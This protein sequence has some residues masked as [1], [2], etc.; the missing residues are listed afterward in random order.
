MTALLSHALIC[1]WIDDVKCNELMLVVLAL[2]NG[3]LWSKNTQPK[4]YKIS[5]E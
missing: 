4:A 3:G 5:D 2:S 1:S